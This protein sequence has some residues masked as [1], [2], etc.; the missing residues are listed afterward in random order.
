MIG[1]VR[2]SVSSLH[3]KQVGGL[4]EV[5][6]L[7]I[8]EEPGRFIPDLQK[9]IHTPPS[10]PSEFKEADEAKGAKGPK[11]AKEPK[12]DGSYKGR[13]TRSMSMAASSL[14]SVAAAAMEV[15]FGEEL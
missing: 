13:I 4:K 9:L 8:S 6:Q 7:T 5:L 1:E 15:A 11:G 10:Q 14:A 12:A 3:L 2:F